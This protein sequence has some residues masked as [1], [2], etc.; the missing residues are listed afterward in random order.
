MDDPSRPSF[1]NFFIDF[2]GII[3]RAITATN[4]TDPGLTDDLAAEIHRYLD[5]LV[6]LVQPSDIIFIA[7][8]GPAPFAKANQQR[9]RRFQSGRSN[10]PGSFDRCSI[11]PGTEFMQQLHEDLTEFIKNKITSDIT[12]SKPQVI[13]SSAFVPG[14]GE[15]KIM[16]WFRDQRVKPEWNPNQT[17]CFY[18]TDADFVFLGLQ[19]HE[20]YISLLREMDAI[21]FQRDRQ[22]FETKTSRLNWGYD[23]F[24]LVH[25]NL[26]R[27]YLSVDFN[28]KGE[29]LERTIDDYIA[30]SFLIGND[31][32]PCFVD[33][34]IK[35]GGFD[36]MVNIYK[37]YREANSYLVEN[38]DF[39]KHNLSIYLNEVVA[40]Y[41][42]L[43]TKKMELECS[44]EEVQQL[45]TASNKKY[46]SNKY[47]EK[48]TE[49]FDGLVKSMA[50]SILDSFDW[51]LKYYSKGCPSWSWSYPFHYAPPLEFV[52]PFIETHESHF[53]IGQPNPP[54]LQQLAIMP[55]Q[56]IELL[57][58]PLREVMSESSPLHEMYPL[59]FETD[60]NGKKAEWQAVVLIPIPELPALETEYN[61]YIQDVS[62]E[63]M[64]RN[65]LDLDQIYKNNPEPEIINIPT[66]E[67]FKPVCLSTTLPPCVPTIL[68]KPATYEARDVDVFV[69]EQPSKNPSLV[70]TLTDS[71]FQNVEEA[72]QYLDKVVLINWPYL[73]PA[74]VVGAIDEQHKVFNTQKELKPNNSPFDTSVTNGTLLHSLAVAIDTKVLLVVKPGNE[75]GTFDD[76]FIDCPAPL[77][78]LDPESSTAIEAFKPKDVRVPQKGEKIAFVGGIAKG[79]TGLLNEIVKPTE[80]SAEVTQRTHPTGIKKLFVD[81]SRNWIKADSITR[82]VG[83]SFKAL[84]FA[85][86]VVEIKPQ[87]INIALA[88]YTPNHQY[89]V[90]GACKKSDHDYLF[91][92]NVL[93]LMQEYFKKTGKLKDLLMEAGKRGD[94]KAGP[95]TLT[96][97]YGGTTQEQEVKF[98]AL[99][100]WLKENAPAG[101]YP[102]TSVN[103]DFPSQSCMGQL[104]TIITKFSA[105]LANKTVDDL[106]SSDIVWKG[107]P[108]TKPPSELPQLGQRVLCVASY[109][110]APFGEFGTVIGFDSENKTVTVLFD[111]VLTCGS[112]LE[113]RLRTNRG[114]RVNLKDLVIVM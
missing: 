62:E 40:E 15:H 68:N 56:S 39:N 5:M 10:V 37:K 88:L 94:R 24:E 96:D 98:A 97:L 112:K 9:T 59:S 7:L 29:D 53:E 111:N 1:N 74:Y 114:L 54:F 78:I 99:C 21:H 63:D 22:A 101:K 31:F 3:Y 93:Q 13:Y 18:S 16:N 36:R 87:N 26:I 49:D 75:D 65:R 4:H 38:G 27:E 23:A 85:M 83:I 100:D 73:R 12:W 48:V 35:A 95:Y 43:Y 42:S 108:N 103:S 8:D 33:I 89:V 11:A 67:I 44:E 64:V 110:T 57:P 34:D 72:Q 102:L 70:V 86:T 106:N 51:V 45:F 76:K 77:C 61:K 69:F 71:I 28:A 14:E 52:L 20:P 105:N 82:S 46:L 80:Y 113:G 109:G 79:C 58:E 6:Q 84:R 90:D 47:P 92:P 25:F 60:L 66:G 107:K 17:H 30:L 55:P 104:E 81:D 41:R 91:A 32:I 50:N 2:N 19:T